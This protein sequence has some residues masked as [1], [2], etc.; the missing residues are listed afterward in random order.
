MVEH[1]WRDVEPHDVALQACLCN[2]WSP[3]V[4]VLRERGEAQGHS[5]L[6]LF[7]VIRHL[8][9]YDPETA[10]SSNLSCTRNNEYDLLHRNAGRATNIFC[11]SL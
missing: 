7:L 3:V 10:S 5:L 8:R 4:G 6:T 11:F 1:A 2:P 9:Q